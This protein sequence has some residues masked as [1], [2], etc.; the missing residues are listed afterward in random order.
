MTATSG[1]EW[2]KEWEGVE[3]TFP[4][5][6]VIEIRPVTSELL[7]K[8]G[9]IPDALTPL[10]INSINGSGSFEFDTN[11]AE[12][13]KTFLQL[14]DGIAETAFVNPRIVKEPAADDEIAIEHVAF[15]DKYFLLQFLNQPTSAL[16]EFRDK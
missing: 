13:F 15:G 14:L 12:N 5:G 1:K 7:F 2:R 4:S 6:K 3:I 8:L 10:V 11:D 16:R 9:R